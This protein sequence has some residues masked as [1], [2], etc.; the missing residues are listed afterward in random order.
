MDGVMVE[1]KN[2]MVCSSLVDAIE[3]LMAPVVVPPLL[4]LYF[5]DGQVR[6]GSEGSGKKLPKRIGLRTLGVPETQHFREKVKWNSYG[7]E[8][9]DQAVK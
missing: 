6:L 3:L 2:M 8:S 5:L 7:L 4:L 9:K 1:D